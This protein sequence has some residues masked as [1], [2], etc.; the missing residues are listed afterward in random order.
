M[1]HTTAELL[2]SAN[3]T[4]LLTHLK[5]FLI[6]CYG[7][8]W[9]RIFTVSEKPG[10]YT[11]AEF[12]HPLTRDLRDMFTLIFNKPKPLCDS[13]Q[14]EHIRSLFGTEME[15]I[16]STLLIP[17]QFEAQEALLAVASDSRHGYSQSIELDLLLSIIE[18]ITGLSQ[19]EIQQRV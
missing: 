2:T 3:N 17:F 15:N 8:K 1:Q 4:D 13:L 11:A 9:V 19:I 12:I 18:L 7:A 5:D 14:R 16:H 6:G 10:I